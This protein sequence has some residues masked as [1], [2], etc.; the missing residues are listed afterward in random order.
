MLAQYQPVLAIAT[1]LSLKT[2]FG[3]FVG[4]RCSGPDLRGLAGSHAGV[5]G[6]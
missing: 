3:G 2:L 6:G 5:A 4:L 1:S